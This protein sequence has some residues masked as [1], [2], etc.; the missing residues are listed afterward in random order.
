MSKVQSRRSVVLD[1]KKDR[2]IEGVSAEVIAVM[3]FSGSMSGLY[4]RGAVQRTL[5]RLL[6]FALAFDDDGSIDTYLFH[7]KSIN[8][9]K[10]ITAQNL[11]GY[12]DREIIGKYTMGGTKYAPIIDDIVSKYQKTSGGFLGIGS[13]PAPR[14]L[15]AYVLFFTDGEND[16]KSYAEQA[17]R[18]A[19]KHGIFFQF[20]GIGGETFRFLQ[21][22]DD[23]PG[24]AS[25]IA[26]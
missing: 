24:R 14:E 8:L 5:E 12:V 9:P 23:L 1:L 26:S 4:R 3:D 13:R 10:A 19:S 22:L 11:E 7:D 15:P 20:V 6:S 2:G 21:K 16:D 17:I 25:F 18:E